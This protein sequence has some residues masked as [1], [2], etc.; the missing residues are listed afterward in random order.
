M[1]WRSWWLMSRSSFFLLFSFI[2][3]HAREISWSPVREPGVGGAVTS[4]A[5]NPANPQQILAAGDMLGPSASDDGGST[6]GDSFGLK[7]WECTEAT[8]KPG[9]TTEVWLGTMGGPYVSNDG[10][11]H[12]RE[13]RDGFPVAE[14]Y[15]G[16][17]AP[18]QK[19]LFAPGKTNHL[20][21][22]GGCRREWINTNQAKSGYGAVWESKDGGERWT[23]KSTVAAG[24]DIRS[25]TFAGGGRA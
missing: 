24:A 19:I 14:T 12:W 20:L 1:G 9:S 7:N 5:V 13:K 17:S 4:L 2:V 11:R 25:A 8:W 6:W 15:W 22:F 18:I 23:L 16:Y 21:A 10:G 3:I